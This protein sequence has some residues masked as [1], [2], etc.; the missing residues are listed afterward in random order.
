MAPRKDCPL[1]SAIPELEW[2]LSREEIHVQMDDEV[3]IACNP[4]LGSLPKRE[5]HT[6]KMEMYQEK[7]S[8]T[9]KENLISHD[10][11]FFFQLL[12][13][14]YS[15]SHINTQHLGCEHLGP[16]FEVLV[17]CLYYQGCKEIQ[18]GHRQ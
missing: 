5:P 12:L 16:K 3:P 8:R 13:F 17:E 18:W 7:Q 11:Y 1:P 10:V 4:H 2:Q 9:L 14:L 15:L 6:E